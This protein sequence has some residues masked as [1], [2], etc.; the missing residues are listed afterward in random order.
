MMQLEEYLLTSPWTA[1]QHIWRI[2]SPD[3]RLSCKVYIARTGTMARGIINT[4][5]NGR[6]PAGAAVAHSPCL[7]IHFGKTDRR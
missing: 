5:T 6:R 3:V 4:W 2:F 1:G 7:G